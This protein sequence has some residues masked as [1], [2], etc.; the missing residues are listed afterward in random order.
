MRVDKGTSRYPRN[1]SLDDMLSSTLQ[2]HTRVQRQPD[3]QLKH[4]PEV[5]EKPIR[6]SNVKPSIGL[7]ELL[8]ASLQAYLRL[9]QS[10][11]YNDEQPKISNN[12]VTTRQPNDTFLQNTAPVQNPSTDLP[13]QRNVSQISQPPVLSLLQELKKAQAEAELQQ[14][15]KDKIIAEALQ[16]HLDEQ[17]EEE[18][19]EERR[20]ESFNMCVICLEAPITCGFLHS[21]RSATILFMA[22]LVTEH[23][24]PCSSYTDDRIHACIE[25]CV[26]SACKKL[27]TIPLEMNQP[28]YNPTTFIR[29]SCRISIN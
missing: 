25:P 14:D 5:E 24:H 15:M 11:Q 12:R 28:I 9:Q 7:E 29:R 2:A 27:W 20:E 6:N 23:L 22:T 13:L 19:R 8:S 17:R 1:I 18:R 16:S 4:V 3:T 26:W 21:S 10:S